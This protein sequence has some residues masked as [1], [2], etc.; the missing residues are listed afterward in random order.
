MNPAL[1]SIASGSRSHQNIGDTFYGSSI[2][3]NGKQLSTFILSY[4]FNRSGFI[5]D[6]RLS[7]VS[8]HT[9]KNGN[10]RFATDTSRM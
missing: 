3:Y 9:K 5:V 8:W 1:L 6:N 7:A 2:I 10:M 4:R